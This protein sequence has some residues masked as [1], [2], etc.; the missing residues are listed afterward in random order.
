MYDIFQTKER[1]QNLESIAIILLIEFNN[2][3][4]NIRKHADRF[5]SCLVDKFPHLLWSKAVLF[6]MLNALQKLSLHVHDEEVQ[7]VFVGRMR[8]RVILMDTV[9]GREDIFQEFAQRS[10]EFVRTSVEWAP[11]TVQSHLQVNKKL[12]G[13][14]IYVVNITFKGI[15][16]HRED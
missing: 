5:L 12:F 13:C 6:G 16:Q 8:R 10:K 1:D 4:K 9:E 7:E 2:P 3:N 15:H 11:D 14:F